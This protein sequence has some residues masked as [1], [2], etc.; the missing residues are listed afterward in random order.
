MT[1]E[2]MEKAEQAIEIFKR[3]YGSPESERINRDSGSGFGFVF[4]ILGLIGVISPRT[5]W[6]LEVGWKVKDAEPT[7]I[8]LVINRL[9]GIIIT[10]IG[11]VILL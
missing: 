8:A 5:A 3:T 7:E 9:F 1:R 10:I 4:I 11:I 6:M 2:E